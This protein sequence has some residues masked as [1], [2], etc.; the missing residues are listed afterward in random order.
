MWSEHLDLFFPQSWIIALLFPVVT[1]TRCKDKLNQCSNWDCSV[2]LAIMI[3]IISKPVILCRVL[4]QGYG[5]F[6]AMAHCECSRVI[7]KYLLDG[8]AKGPA[9]VQM[10]F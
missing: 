1:G 10:E 4:R 5:S 8:T 9:G 2:V 3:H 7:S 6:Q